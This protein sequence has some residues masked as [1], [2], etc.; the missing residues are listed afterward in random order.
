MYFQILFCFLDN[1]DIQ[2]EVTSVITLVKNAWQSKS[3]VDRKTPC[4][5][6]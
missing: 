5:Q 2:F 3:L 1:R 6:P 4:G